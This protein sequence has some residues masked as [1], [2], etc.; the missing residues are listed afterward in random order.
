[1]LSPTTAL[2]ADTVCGSN[3]H[4]GGHIVPHRETLWINHVHAQIDR[5]VADV[6]IPGSGHTFVSWWVLVAGDRNDGNCA[7]G[8]CYMQAGYSHDYHFPAGDEHTGVL[9][10]WEYSQGLLCPDTCMAFSNDWGSP[11]LGDAH[12]FGVTRMSDPSC[13]T[14]S[15]SCLVAKV[16]NVPG[17]CGD[18]C[19][20]TDFDPHNVWDSSQAQILGETPLPGADMPG[21]S[22]D[23][24]TF[25]DID[26]TD[27]TDNG[28]FAW[29]SGDPTGCSYYYRSNAMFP[30][31]HFTIWTNPINHGHS[32]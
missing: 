22:A 28:S 21:T 24:V 20:Y 19:P 18:R 23:P 26:E 13:I 14:N 12:D 9:Y 31:T 7:G 6:C 8:T 16:N 25:S 5:Q 1:M 3:T 27:G 15:G 30:Y 4:F 29:S 17:Q 10:F 2:G 32:C 11:N